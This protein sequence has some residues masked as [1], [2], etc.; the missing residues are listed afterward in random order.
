MI[1]PDHEICASTDHRHWTYTCHWCPHRQQWSLSRSAWTE[2]GTGGDPTDYVVE[3]AYLG[4]F[5]G[6]QAVMSMVRMWVANDM[7]AFDDSPPRL[8]G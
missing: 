5:D 7:A 2:T 8:P 6:T 3:T 1:P 4:P